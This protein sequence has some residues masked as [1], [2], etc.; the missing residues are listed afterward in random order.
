MFIQFGVNYLR[1]KLTI[2]GNLR[3]NSL[4]ASYFLIIT[5]GIVA[6]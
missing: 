5:K 1:P 2:E 4:D 3:P 6:L